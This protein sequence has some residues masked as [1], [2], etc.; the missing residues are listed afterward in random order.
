MLDVNPNITAQLASGEIRAFTLL[1]LTLG[2]VTLGYTECDVPIAHNGILYQPRGYKLGAISQSLA[3]IVDSATLDIDNLDDQLTPY[4][5]GGNPQGAPA[6]IL[7]VALDADYELLGAY[8]DDHV[9]LFSGSLDDWQLAEGNLSVTITSEMVAWHQRT[10]RMQSS[11]CSWRV[12]KGPECQYAGE[13]SRC[14]RSYA[15][16]AEL[17]NTANFGGERWLPS[18]EGSTIWW[19]KTPEVSA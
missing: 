15:R 4:F 2:G 9:L 1:K 6:E 18:I 8:P 3:R 10:A 19:G 12:F 5:V 11:S 7:L 16:C 17:G 14:N 13:Q